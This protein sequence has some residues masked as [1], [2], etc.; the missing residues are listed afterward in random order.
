M[1]G[2]PVSPLISPLLSFRAKGKEKK[3]KK[4]LGL[5]VPP[6]AAETALM[7][8]AARGAVLEVV[9]VGERRAAA[10][11]ADDLAAGL[12]A[13]YVQED[14]HDEAAEDADAEDGDHDVVA[15]AV[16]VGAGHRVGGPARVQRVR[17]DDA[18]Q[19]A[20]ARDQGRGGRHADLAV[21]PLEDLVR[22]RHAGRHR[23]AEPEPHHQQPAVPGPGPGYGGERDGQEPG[24]LDQ[25]RAGEEDRPEP[26]EPV[27]Y[28]GDQQDRD[29]V[30]LRRRVREDQS[31]GVEEGRVLGITYN[32]D[33]REQQA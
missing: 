14:E 30:H 21:A 29:Q 25:A 1:V 8:L 17:R 10:A 27:G 19:V 13:E 26:V 23:R 5:L 31:A 22:P 18:A 2:Q 15:A 28:G 20:Q 11:A 32:P 16:L 12:V 9:G 3:K 24:D 33:G 7:D 6:E 4:G